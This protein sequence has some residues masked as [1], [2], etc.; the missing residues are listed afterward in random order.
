MRNPLEHTKASPEERRADRLLWTAFLI[1][2]L[3]M[4]VN[5]IV[6]F[7]VAH[8]TTDTGQMHYSYLVSAIDFLLC[9]C[10]L[11]MSVLLHRR[12][13][14]FEDDIPIDGRRSFMAK[15]SILISIITALL[16]IAQTLALVTLHPID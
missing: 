1:S 12:F 5:T 13:S 16:V 6:G 14:Q 10:A 8:W 2:P 3:A 7:T 4:G 15:L 11:G 9:L